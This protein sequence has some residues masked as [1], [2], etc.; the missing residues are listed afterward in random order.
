[1]LWS[2]LTLFIVG[3]IF[4]FLKSYRKAF[5]GMLKRNGAK[6]V[7]LNLLNELLNSF[8][9]VCSTLAGT[10]LSVALVSFISQGVQPFIVMMI[11]I[12]ITKLFPKVEKENVAKKEIIKRVITIIACIIGLACIEFG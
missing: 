8:G 4:V 5:S 10:M 11:G 1:M 2:N 9:G 6:I 12:I 7:G 3:I